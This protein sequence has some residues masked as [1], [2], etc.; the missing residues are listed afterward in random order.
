[1]SE[2]R[3]SRLDDG[4]RMNREVHVRF[5]ERRGVRFPPATHPICAVWERGE[6]RAT[7]WADPD[8]EYVVG[9]PSPGSGSS[10][11]ISGPALNA[12]YERRA[13]ASFSA[14]ERHS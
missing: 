3:P 10:A 6:F 9:G 14:G 13:S 5:C 12:A 11:S 7:D 4:S 2:P 8:I 1:V